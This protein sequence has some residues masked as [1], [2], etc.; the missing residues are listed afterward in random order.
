MYC[1][2]KLQQSS[3]WNKKQMFTEGIE[4]KIYSFFN[5]CARWG[6]CSTSLLARFTPWKDPVLI[7]LEAGWSSEPVWTG[8]ENLAPT[9]I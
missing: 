4:V 9:E 6:G 3:P 5:L 7:V 2:V 8:A 1:H